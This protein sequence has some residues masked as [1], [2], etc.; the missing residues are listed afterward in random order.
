MNKDMK[1]IRRHSL[2]RTCILSII[3]FMITIITYIWFYE[4]RISFGII[5]FFAIVSVVS[6]G[7][8]KF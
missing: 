3:A 5:H 4:Q 2:K 8:M 6:L 7:F 1:M